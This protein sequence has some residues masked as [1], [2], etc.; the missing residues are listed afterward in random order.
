MK[1]FS[2]NY[3]IKPPSR[4]PP[5]KNDIPHEISRS[6]MLGD[7]SNDMGLRHYCLGFDTPWVEEG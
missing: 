1:I 6:C 5:V 4:K 7:I 2:H 3:Y